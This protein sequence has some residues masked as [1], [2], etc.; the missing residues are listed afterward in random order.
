MRERERERDHNER[1]SLN[2][3]TCGESQTLFSVKQHLFRVL[4]RINGI[5]VI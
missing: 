5:S 4:H 1:E 3:S 2:C